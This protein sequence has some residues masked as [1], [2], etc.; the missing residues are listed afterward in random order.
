MRSALEKFEI[1]LIIHT[2]DQK[3]APHF[4]HSMKSLNRNF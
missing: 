2:A 1:S 4:R 3:V